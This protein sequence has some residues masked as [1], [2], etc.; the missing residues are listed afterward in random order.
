V[1]V[2]ACDPGKLR[3]YTTGTLVAG[4]SHTVVS[5]GDS[6]AQWARDHPRVPRLHLEEL[7]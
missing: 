5:L 7:L 4:L 6:T 2:V 3:G 1:R